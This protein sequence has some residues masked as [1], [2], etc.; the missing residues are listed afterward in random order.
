VEK[1]EAKGTFDSE[2]LPT[3]H[4]HGRALYRLENWSDAL[5]VSE[6]IAGWHM[7]VSGDDSMQ[8]AMALSNVGATANRLGQ[9]EV[10]RATMERAMGITI[11]RFGETSY[12]ATQVFAKMLQFKL[13]TGDEKPQ[14][15]SQEK[16]MEEIKRILDSE[17][18]D[19][20]SE[21]E[22]L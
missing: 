6:K 15:Y 2:Y 4:Q 9:T 7:Q 13:Y 1:I 20:E 14:G 8:F 10:V 21:T 18:K 11:A 19:D 22:E 17:T 12:E 16:Y 3:L 5:E